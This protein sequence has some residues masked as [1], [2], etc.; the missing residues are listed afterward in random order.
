VQIIRTQALFFPRKGQARKP[1]RLA[2]QGD[3]Q[4]QRVRR[5][6]KQQRGVQSRG[7]ALEEDSSTQIPN[8]LRR[9]EVRA[10]PDTVEDS[11]CYHMSIIY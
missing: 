9:R 8:P 1:E 11:R 3:T 10:L 2:T 6:G 4:Q 7:T 5:Q